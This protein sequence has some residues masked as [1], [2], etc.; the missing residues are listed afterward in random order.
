MSAS[1][2]APGLA[3]APQTS[4]SNITAVS[5]PFRFAVY[6]ACTL[7]ALITSYALGK[8]LPFDALNYH[9]YAGMSALNDRSAQDYFAAGPQSYFNPYAYVPF[10]LMV[11][12]GMSSIE[13]SSVLAVVHSVILWLTFELAVS[14]CPSEH[15]PTRMKLGVCAVILTSANPILIQQLGSSFA[16]ITTAI[17][18]LGGWLLLVRAEIT[19]RAAPVIYAGLLLGAATGLKPTNAVHA[20]AALALP[21]LLPFDL[22]TRFRQGFLFCLSILAGF[23]IV[24]GS[25]SLH[26]YRLFGNPFF[27]MMNGIFR[28]PEFTTEP[29]RHFRFIPY[30]LSE[31]LWRPFAI[32]DPIRMVHEELSSPDLRYAV[33]VVLAL[34]LAGRWF[35]TRVRPPSQTKQNGSASSDRIL[36]ALGCGLAADWIMWLSASGNG[37]YFLPM[38]SVAAVLI[39]ALLFRLLAAKPIVR[40]YVIAAIFGV[41]GIQL[42]MGAEFRWNEVP[43]HGPWLSVEVPQK[44]R[45]ERN[46]YLSEGTMS[47]SFIAAYLA[48]DSGFIN[49]T[50]GYALG[51]AGASGSRIGAL[52]GRFAPHLRVLVRGD[53]VYED[54]DTT[55]EPHRSQIDAPLMRFGLRV[56]TADCETIAINAPQSGQEATDDSSAAPYAPGNT[57]HLVSC[58]IFPDATDHSQ[59]LVEQ[60]AADMILDRLE[61]ACPKLFQPR[62]MLTEHRG[63]AWL[64][65][66]ID[67]DVWAWVSQGGVKFYQANS[68]KFLTWLGRESDWAKA[69]LRLACGRRDNAYFAKVLDPE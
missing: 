69:P 37:R 20:L 31:A 50:G 65:N 53:N 15:R 16:D 56:D 33:L 26:L 14:L 64:R 60:H 30:S 67:T 43:W 61:D 3:L 68:G 2:A 17:L 55:H 5:L 62:R 25:W 32:V 8:D 9:L 48:K 7:T 45:S 24:A 49:F 63:H 44:L 29:I 58:R 59:E 27:P 21:I 54:G 38:A 34:A 11:R 42:W 6:A 35:W 10:Y 46:L 52:I 39:V 40:N 19:P 13:I 4:S 23:A 47:N 1:Q 22:R 57:G 51:P 66:Y 18:V 36:T 12:A 28:S 41:Q